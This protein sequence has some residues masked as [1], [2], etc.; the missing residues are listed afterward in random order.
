MTLREAS[1]NCGV[2]EL[3]PFNSASLPDSIS[4]P[5]AKHALGRVM[6]QG[7]SVAGAVAEMFAKRPIQLQP[8]AMTAVGSTGESCSSMRDAMSSVLGSLCLY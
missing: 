1:N 4:G 7:C 3:R 8:V 2:T 5:T 6:H